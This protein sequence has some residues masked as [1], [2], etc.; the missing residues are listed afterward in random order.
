MSI[1]IS[2]SRPVARKHYE[3]NAC[4]F[5]RDALADGLEL[6]YSEAKHVVRA[7]QNNWRIVPGQ[8]HIKIFGKDGG[9]AYS[10]RC[11][12]EIDRLCQKYDLY[13]DW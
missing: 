7:R 6:P 8:Q 5:L 13:G 12:I 3:C 11:I 1:V 4:L 10:I 2:E 9:E